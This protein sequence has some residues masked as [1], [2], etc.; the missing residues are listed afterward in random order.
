MSSRSGRSFSATSPW[1]ISAAVI[2]D[3]LLIG[4]AGIGNE[5]PAAVAR[6]VATLIAG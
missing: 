1:F 3:P 4:I 6:R 5:Q 2:V